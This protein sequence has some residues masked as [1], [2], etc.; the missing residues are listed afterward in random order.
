[1]SN[2]ILLNWV[3]L[4]NAVSSLPKKDQPLNAKA[5]KQVFYDLL[6]WYREFTDI[7][8]VELKLASGQYEKT[9]K[10]RGKKNSTGTHGAI[11]SAIEFLSAYQEPAEIINMSRF[12]AGKKERAALVSMTGRIASFHVERMNSLDWLVD[13]LEKNDLLFPS[14][15]YRNKLACCFSKVKQKHCFNNSRKCVFEP[16]LSWIRVPA[17]T[18]SGALA[19]DDCCH[20][21][22]LS[23][24]SGGTLSCDCVA[25]NTGCD[26]KAPNRLCE[27]ND[28]NILVTAAGFRDVNC[29]DLGLEEQEPGLEKLP[30]L[31]FDPVR[32][33]G[34]MLD[35]S[36]MLYKGPLST[37]LDA[38]KGRF[39]VA[40]S[41]IPFNLGR[42]VLRAKDCDQ[43]GFC[44]P[45]A[46]VCSG[47]C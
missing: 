46:P 37:S 18:V 23:S 36:D 42:L 12:G 13:W 10:E 24:C 8:D 11:L 9:A 25:G 16:A 33:G 40:A 19:D 28:K 22:T 2:A 31:V 1:M 32:S 47:L 17:A 4:L 27:K 38:G 6:E 7:P 30:C 39:M 14:T 20:G 35:R 15:T 45:K 3:N 29:P 44:P 43:T 21:A 5:L 41:G 26:C 34:C